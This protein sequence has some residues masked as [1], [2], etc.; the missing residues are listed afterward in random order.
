M[1]GRGGGWETHSRAL[2]KLGGEHRTAVNVDGRWLPDT[3]A[4][5]LNAQLAVVFFFVCIFLLSHHYSC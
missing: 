3:D 1:W 4:P 5:T 2:V